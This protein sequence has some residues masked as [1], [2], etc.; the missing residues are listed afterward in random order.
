MEFFINEGVA[1]LIEP[2]GEGGAVVVGDGRLR[3]DAAFAGKGF[4]PWPDAVATQVVIATEQYNRIARMIEQHVPVTLEMNIASSYH[5]AE[6][7][8][9][10]IIAEL[11]GTDPAAGVVMLGAHFDSWHAATG[12]A[13]NAAGCAVILEAMR[14][15]KASG[16]KARR[17]VRLALWTGAEQGYLGSRGYVT[18]HFADPATMKLKP[19]HAALSV[20]F[21]LD[22]GSGAIRG[23]NLQGNSRRRADLRTLDRPTQ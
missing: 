8:S 6:Y 9:F 14:I 13:D 3:D 10:N 22:G 11:P 23:I 18:E 19:E 1:A 12:A 17:T 7:D 4:Y 2:G 5:P 15:L 21:N 16:L 20:Y